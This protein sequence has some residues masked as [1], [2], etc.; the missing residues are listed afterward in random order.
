MLSRQCPQ[1]LEDLIGGRHL[2]DVVDVDIADDPAL[3]HHKDRPLGMS[4]RAQH[5]VL[6]CHRPM[7]PEV[8][9][10]GVVHPSQAF[11]PGLQAGDMIYAYTQDL[12]I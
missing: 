5:P 6:H 12:G 1:C 9:Q 10:Q 8:A 4:L 3:I 7:R 2:R 11:R